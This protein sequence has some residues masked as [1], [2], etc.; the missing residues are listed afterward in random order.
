MVAGKEKI[1][2]FD[3]KIDNQQLSS[4]FHPYFAVKSF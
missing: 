4:I 1:E 2:G 3:R